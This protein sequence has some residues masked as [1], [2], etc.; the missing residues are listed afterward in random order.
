[1][2]AIGELEQGNIPEVVALLLIC[3]VFLKTAT[4]DELSSFVASHKINWA[5]FY[6]IARA[7]HIRPVVNKVFGEVRI[8][9]PTSGRLQA[10]CMQITRNNFEHYR[11]LLRLNNLFREAGI[12]AV[13]Y[14][15]CLFSLQFYEDINL[16]EFSDL[17]FLIYPDIK[18]VH[19][20]TKIMEKA[21]Y[22]IGFDAPEEFREFYFSHIREFKFLLYA[23]DKRKFLAEFHSLMNDPVF[24]TAAP[25]ANEYLFTDLYDETLSGSQI[26]LLSPTR[27][28]I[29]ML[30]HHGIREQW[31]SLK[32]VMD[33]AMVIK[34]GDLVDWD[35][36]F[37][38]SK[39]YKFSKVL[40]VGLD[41]ADDLLGVSLGRPH[42]KVVTTPW[43]KRLFSK[44]LQKTDR[45]WRYNFSLKLR[46]KDSA[47]DRWR[48][49]YKH[50]LYLG[51]PSIL[52]YK[53]VR[54]PKGLFYLYVFIKP[55]RLLKKRIN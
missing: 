9:E 8:D 23:N 42:A 32:N 11:E 46:S 14:K 7:H 20:I 28:F 16:R 41:L 21:G 24:E 4:P 54:L 35:F 10:D 49:L 25:I 48:M 13:P 37:A 6:D 36:V 27:H 30:T 39:E 40:A 3:R 44:H 33:L 51:T 43:A 34:G 53:F 1:M 15:G 55:L 19:A 12:M 52:D 29:A 50:V 26:R 17:D 45:T 38:C 18:D 31:T 22:V 2:R 47:A 5:L